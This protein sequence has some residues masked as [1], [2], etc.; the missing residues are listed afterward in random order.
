[1][2][3]VG[4]FFCWRSRVDRL[5][6]DGRDGECFTTQEALIDYREPFVWE[7]IAH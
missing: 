1:M 5:I 2:L 7:S 3:T 4:V 6:K